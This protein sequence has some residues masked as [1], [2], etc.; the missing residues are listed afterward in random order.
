MRAREVIMKINK[1]LDFKNCTIIEELGKYGVG[2][3]CFNIIKGEL[4]YMEKFR[5][6]ILSN[7][8]KVVI[9]DDIIFEVVVNIKKIKTITDGN[10]GVTVIRTI[11]KELIEK[12][13]FYL[14]KGLIDSLIER[15]KCDY[16]KEVIEFK[17]S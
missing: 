3:E 13:T 15:Y 1:E 5:K 6:V 10:T 2:E 4:Y 9:D 12:T 16:N 17:K 7:Q 8:A 14:E 11:Y